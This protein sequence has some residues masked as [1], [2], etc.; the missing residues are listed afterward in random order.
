[1]IKYINGVGTYRRY[2][3]KC[4]TWFLSLRRLGEVCSN[5]IRINESRKKYYYPNIKMKGGP[6]KKC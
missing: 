4:N 2:C 6:L 3:R 5:C 1:M